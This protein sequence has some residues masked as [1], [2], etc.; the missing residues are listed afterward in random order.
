L[1]SEDCL[2][3]DVYAP[4]KAFKSKKKLP[5]YFFIQGGGFAELSNA[6]YNGTGLVEASDHKMLVVT[7]NYRVGPYG[8][9]AGDEVEKEGNL[10]HGLKDQI[11]ALKWVK[12]HISKVSP[13]S[14]SLALQGSNSALIVWR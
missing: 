7:F 14:F 13:T 12:K 3:L 2:F 4:T 8:F 1:K 11:K 6:N 10:N 5:V 9:L